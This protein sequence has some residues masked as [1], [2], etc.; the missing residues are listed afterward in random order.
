MKSVAEKSLEM[1]SLFEVEV[2]VQLLLWRWEHP[3]A[4]D[5]EFAN[6]LLESA[7]AV[8]RDSIAGSQFIEGLPSANMNFVSAVWYVE[9]CAIAQGEGDPT[10]LQ[11]RSDWLAALRRFL[12]SC[13]CDPEYLQ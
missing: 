12:P 5:A 4:D 3:L 1:T 13:F 7:S 10:V 9:S 8:L 11:A 6:S 2:F